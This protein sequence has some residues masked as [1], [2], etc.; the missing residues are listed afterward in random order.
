MDAS[1]TLSKGK[2]LIMSAEYK[3]IAVK[4]HYEVYRDGEFFCSADNHLEA[5]KEIEKDRR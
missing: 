2:E 4:G 3:I 5:T 1:S